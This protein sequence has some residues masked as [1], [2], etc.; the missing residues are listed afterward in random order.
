MGWNHQLVMRWCVKKVTTQSLEF[1]HCHVLLSFLQ[2]WKNSPVRGSIPSPTRSGSFCS[3]CAISL[4][5]KFVGRHEMSLPGKATG[6]EPQTRS[7]CL[8]WNQSRYWNDAVL[9][10]ETK[11]W[12]ESRLDQSLPTVVLFM[13]T[14]IVIIVLRDF[15]NLL[16]FRSILVSSK[17]SAR[18]KD[19]LNW[20]MKVV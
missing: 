5:G 8:G 1:L 15:G 3:S 13:P 17:T 9:H 16:C 18:A 4:P 20:A 12:Y 14:D 6:C 11:N 10:S 19:H 7:A 2:C